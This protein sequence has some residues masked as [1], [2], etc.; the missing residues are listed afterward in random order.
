[1]ANLRLSREIY[2]TPNTYIEA[3]SEYDGNVGEN[4]LTAPT[5]LKWVANS[6]TTEY[7]YGDLGENKE[8]TF[9]SLLGVNFSQSGTVTIRCRLSVNAFVTSPAYDTTHDSSDVFGDS[10]VFPLIVNFWP[11]SEASPIT[12]RYWRVDITDSSNPDTRVEIGRVVIG[13]HWSPSVNMDLGYSLGFVDRSPVNYTTGSI[14]RILKKP[15]RRTASFIVS[16]VTR[17]ER[18]NLAKAATGHEVFLSAYPEIADGGTSEDEEVEQQNTLVGIMQSNVALRA[19]SGT[20]TGAQ[21]TVLEDAAISGG[22][23]ADMSA[24][25]LRVE[26]NLSDLDDAKT[27][28]ENLEIETDFARVNMLDNAGMQEWQRSTNSTGNT[29]DG[30][31]AADRWYIDFTQSASETFSVSK[32]T[33]EAL[34]TGIQPVGLIQPIQIDTSAAHGGI[35]LT[36]RLEEK[37]IDLATQ[38]CTLS[39]WFKASAAVT[40]DD[41]QLNVRLDNSGTGDTTNNFSPTSV[42]YS[43]GDW[44]RYEGTVAYATPSTTRGS[45]PYLELRIGSTSSQTARWQ[46]VKIAG[47]KLE[48]GAQASRYEARD[49]A[50]ELA[51]CQ[52]HYQKSAGTNNPGLFVGDVTNTELYYANIWFPT[53]MHVAPTVALTYYQASRFPTTVGTANNI[54]V[55]GFLI[56]KTCNSTGAAGY[57][58]DTWTAATGW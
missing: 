48:I 57:F 19:L 41:L 20:R 29:T 58:R 27:A 14:A 32:P 40:L 34:G 5:S 22:D 17:A 46:G 35:S 45:L 7:L 13:R 8:V 30:V 37:W 28:R 21:I 39:F 6:D 15:K 56:Q 10:S 50:Q 31:K 47:I 26:N 2:S 9:V 52:R 24:L 12:A 54:S 23:D 4:V 38:T 49:S 44:V 43:S 53:S 33:Q 55:D 11:G 1:M 36:Q 18:I 16:H 3:S 51:A 42:S 25:W